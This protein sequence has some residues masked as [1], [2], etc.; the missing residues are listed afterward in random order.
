M[1]R[2]M[3]I[4]NFFA[5]DLGESLAINA[6]PFTTSAKTI[7]TINRNRTI[8]INERNNGFPQSEVSCIKFA[9]FIGQ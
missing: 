2:K 9:G 8:P 5:V 3:I 7:I 4:P 6:E 1:K